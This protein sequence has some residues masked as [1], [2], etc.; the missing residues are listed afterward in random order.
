MKIIFLLFGLILQVPLVAQNS[1]D[2][3]EV[4][5]EIQKIIKQD[6]EKQVPKLKLKLE[7]EKE[8]LVQIEF[9]LD[10]FR[11]E[12]FMSKW[13]ELD[14]RDFDMRDAG[15]ETARLYDSLLNKYYKKLQAVLK[16]DDKKV[17]V[18]AQK[19]WLAY[20]DNETKLVETISKDEYSGGGTMQ[21]L[22]EASQY[23]DLIKTRTVAIFEHY[24]RATQSE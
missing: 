10:T 2:P 13:V 11:L 9:I 12:H 23:L 24:V 5:P 21:G 1:K 7:K 16:G 15:Y 22:T 17:L 20:R 19:A 18:Q 4:T 8:N 3:I 14:Y 6:V